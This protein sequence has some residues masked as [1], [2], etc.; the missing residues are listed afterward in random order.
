MENE[1]YYRKNLETDKLNVYTTKDFYQQL[2]S[3]QKKVLTHYCLWSNKQECWVSKARA[4]RANYLISQLN[5]LGFQKRDDYGEKLSF[6]EQINRQ[7]EKAAVRAERAEA[8]AV[9]AEYRSEELLNKAREMAG[10]IPFGQPILVG[11]HSEKRDRN[12]RNKIHNTFGK[13]FAEQDKAAYYEQK[14]E[15]ARETA[16]GAKFSNPQ[17]LN[18]RIKECD[19]NLRVLYRRLEGKLYKKS[20]PKEI[21]PEARTFY[22]KRIE[23]EEEKLKSFEG[24]M[25]LIHPDWGRTA[26]NKKSK[27]NGKAI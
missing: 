5:A 2:G 20:P 8:N 19:K 24:K 14:A 13:A 15:N 6:A 27:S 17:Y 10:V 26:A 16:E 9:K 1:N 11:H 18:N 21:T 25:K 3:E 4:D 22:N 12:Y 7:Q 23:E